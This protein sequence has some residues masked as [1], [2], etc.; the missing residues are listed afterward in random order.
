MLLPLKLLYIVYVVLQDCNQEREGWDKGRGSNLAHKEAW[1]HFVRHSTNC[2]DILIVFE[3]DAF[4]GRESAGKS[5]IEFVEKRN[6]STDILYFGYCYQTHNDHPSISHL[7]PYCLHAYALTVHG[8]RKLLEYV[9]A[10]SIFADAAVALLINKKKIIAEYMTLSWDPEYLTRR[11][12]NEGIRWSGDFEYDGAIPQVK[13]IPLP[14]QFKEGDIAC[15]TGSKTV[16][17]FTKNTWRVVPNMDVFVALGLEG[18][19]VYVYMLIGFIMCS[20]HMR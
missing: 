1:D 7:A 4:I 19:L 8:A 11:F 6:V 3:Y 13:L 12:N 17:Y 14:R 20:L 10:C 18:M 15:V 5:A 9:D 2:E 16:Y